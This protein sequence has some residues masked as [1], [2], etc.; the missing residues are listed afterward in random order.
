MTKADLIDET[1]LKA[2]Q[3]Q[4]LLDKGSESVAVSAIN[5]K[6]LSPLFEKIGEVLAEDLNSFADSELV[7]EVSN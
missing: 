3:R 6:S 1:S 2:L 4:V 5:S 7:A